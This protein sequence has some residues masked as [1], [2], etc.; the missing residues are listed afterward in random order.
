MSKIWVNVDVMTPLTVEQAKGLR[1]GTVLYC[2]VVRDSRGMPARWRVSGKPQ[3]WK[4]QPWRV[5]VPVKHGLFANGELTEANV[6][7]VSL[8]DGT[9]LGA[10]D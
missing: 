7:T 4:T 1:V 2:R 10:R 6:A 3:T 9:V 8:I 5:R